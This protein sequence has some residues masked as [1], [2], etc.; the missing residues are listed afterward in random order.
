MIVKFTFQSVFG[1]SRQSPRHASAQC[2]EESLELYSMII[3]SDWPTTKQKLLRRRD[4]VLPLGFADVIF[5][6]ERSDDRK[7][8][9][10]SQ[11]RLRQKATI[12]S[13]F[14]E[15]GFRSQS[16]H[17]RAK[18]QVNFDP[19][20]SGV[21]T[22]SMLVCRPCECTSGN[23]NKTSVKRKVLVP[24]PENLISANPGLKIL[25][26]VLYLPSY[27][28]LRVTFYVII[29]ESRSKNTAVFLSSSDLFLDNKTLLEIWGLS[30]TVDMIWVLLSSQMHLIKG[31]LKFC[32]LSC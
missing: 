23:L 12:L 11:A 15:Q 9:C 25:F 20:L 32:C 31:S 5:G 30:N 14:R 28:L 22:G 26:H 27:A 10:C 2:R 13:A 4:I 8:V 7:Y 24:V 1:N 3:W 16:N 29:A 19:G 18:F 6:R 17:A 21:N